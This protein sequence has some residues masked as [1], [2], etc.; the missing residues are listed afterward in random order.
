MKVAIT[1][2]RKLSSLDEIMIQRRMIDL[3]G[4]TDVDEI[5]FGGAIGADTLALKSALQFCPSFRQILKIV[6]LPFAIGDQPAE[7][8]MVAATHADRIHVDC[9]RGKDEPFRARNEAMVLGLDYNGQ[10]EGPVDLLIAF[11]HGRRRSGTFMTMNIAKK[12]DIP[13]DEVRIGGK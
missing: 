7:A 1:G 8:A 3:I 6:Y 5:R 2:A 4:Y 12:H 11:W 9:G 10:K 13:V